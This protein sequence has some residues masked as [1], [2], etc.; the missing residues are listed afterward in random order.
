LEK[1][2]RNSFKIYGFKTE[3]RTQDPLNT[4]AVRCLHISFKY[5]KKM[6]DIYI[7][8]PI[9]YWLQTKERHA[10]RGYAGFN[11]S[12]HVLRILRT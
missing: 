5:V 6:K 7:L 1:T 8:V 3:I 12:I 11:S 2:R 10:A 4:N 9:T